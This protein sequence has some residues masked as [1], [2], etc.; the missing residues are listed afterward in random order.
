MQF[1]LSVL[2]I[3]VFSKLLCP[4]ESY[5][6]VLSSEYMVIGVTNFKINAYSYQQIVYIYFLLH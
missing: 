1:I 3:K 2:K 4:N 5:I 6:K